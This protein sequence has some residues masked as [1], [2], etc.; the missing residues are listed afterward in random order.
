MSHAIATSPYADATRAR[1]HETPWTGAG[2]NLVR[3]YPGC[4]LSGASPAT[5]R[6]T[7]SMTAPY[8]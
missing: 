3:R 4:R 6:Y 7:Q 8:A 2:A 5:C 1:A